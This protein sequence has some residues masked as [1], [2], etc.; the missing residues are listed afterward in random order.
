MRRRRRARSRGGLQATLT[1][2]EYEFRVTLQEIAACELQDGLASD[3]C[4]LREVERVERL[5]RREVRFLDAPLHAAVVSIDHFAMNEFREEL[6]V[7]RTP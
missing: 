4:L 5:Q 1:A 2:E 3:P 7:R 6:G